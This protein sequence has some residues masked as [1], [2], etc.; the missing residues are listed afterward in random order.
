MVGWA[1]VMWST[2]RTASKQGRKTDE[3][4]LVKYCMNV[5]M[6]AQLIWLD[7]PSKSTMH[8]N[9]E[10]QN[11]DLLE[12]VC[13]I[14]AITANWNWPSWKLSGPDFWEFGKQGLD[15]GQCLQQPAVNFFALCQRWTRKTAFCPL[16]RFTKSI[17]FCGLCTLSA[18][19]WSFIFFTIKGVFFCTFTLQRT[20]P[21]ST[22]GGSLRGQTTEGISV[23]FWH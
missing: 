8:A 2:F 14:K 20:Q 16:C 9:T 22:N 19:D 1:L 23:T 15:G 4:K 10:Y 7:R 11:V 5:F 17:R 12:R 18:K 3:R 21:W 13:L 6:E